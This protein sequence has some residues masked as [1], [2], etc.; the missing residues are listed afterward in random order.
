MRTILTGIIC[1]FFSITSV[2]SQNIDPEI[3]N[4]FDQFISHSN[5]GDWEKAF[6]LL[7]PKLFTK[8][9]KTDLVDMMKSSEA[10]GLT[11]Q[12]QNIQINS[13]SVPVEEGQEEFVR[14]NY[15]G[16]MHVKIT[17]GSTYDDSRTRDVLAEQFKAQYGSKNVN[18]DDKLGTFKIRTVKSMI[19]VRNTVKGGGWKLVELNPEQRDLMNEIFSPSIQAALIY[20]E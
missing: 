13:S 6:E 19:A 7:Y 20:V 4:T 11:I 5:R 9:A 3:R 1:L 18:W 17:R 8:V 2:I 14:L 12:L 16:D 15:E 10:D